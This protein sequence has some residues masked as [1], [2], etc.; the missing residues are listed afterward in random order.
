VDG[1]P[2]VIQLVTQ[3]VD[4]GVAVVAGGDGVGRFGGQDLIGLELAVGPAFIRVSGLQE[5]AAAAAAKVVGAVGVHVDEVLFTDH[6]LDHEA[7]VLGDRVTECFSY[8]LA[9]VLDG[10]LDFAVLVP[11]G[12]GLQLALADP[13]GIVLND[14]FDFEVVVELE[15]IQSEPDCEEFV[16]SLRVEPDLA[17]QI[18]HGFFLHLDDVFPSFVVP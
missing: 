13:L 1:L 5:P 2:G 14:A 16:P 11:F 18:L 17:A 6:R 3:I 8:Q 7:Q 12:T 10:E 9:G 4:L 15:F